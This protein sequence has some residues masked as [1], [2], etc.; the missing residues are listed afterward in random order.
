[1][2]W[3]ALFLRLRA[4]PAWLYAASIFYAGVAHIGELP[5]TPFVPVDKLLHAACFGGL[6]VLV[7]FALADL[8]AFRRRS[9]AILASVGVGVAL[10]FVQAALPYRSADF[11]D[12]LADAVGALLAALVLTLIGRTRLALLARGVRS[13]S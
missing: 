11:F 4:L 13:S 1:M 6:E 7:E 2:S 3:R 9:F 5:Q 10:E 12:A 8:E